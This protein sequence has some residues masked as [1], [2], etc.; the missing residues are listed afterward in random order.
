MEAVPT[1]ALRVVINLK[2]AAG[3]SSNTL[4]RLT[5][6]RLLTLLEESNR[7][8]IVPTDTSRIVEKR[9]Y[10]YHCIFIPEVE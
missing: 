1:Y 10:R 4:E 5:Y 3:Q 6:F 2:F 9:L 7:L 8:V